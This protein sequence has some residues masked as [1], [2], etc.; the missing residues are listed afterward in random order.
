M[1]SLYLVESILSKDKRN[2]DTFE[3]TIQVLS[4][5]ANEK[6]STLVE[7]QVSND[8]TRAFLVLESTSQAALREVFSNSHLAVTL[9]KPV[10]IVG[11]NLDDI[12]KK[13]AKVRYLVE[14]N[15]PEGLTMDAYIERKK[16]SSVHYAEVP[17]VTFQ[18]T[19]VCEDM[20]KCLCFYD[21]PDEEAIFKARKAVGAPVDAITET[22]SVAAPEKTTAK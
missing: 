8:F 9:V 20:T 5:Y 17:E 15:L 22:I 1:M 7:V 12:R 11:A 14:W 4:K 6:E 19:Y 16:K 21:G 2:K 18:R 10:R 3:E 13:D